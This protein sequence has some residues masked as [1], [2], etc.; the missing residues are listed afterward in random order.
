L[1]IRDFNASGV[2]EGGDCSQL[3]KRFALKSKNPN[4]VFRKV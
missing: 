2:D 1:G 4:K 3:P